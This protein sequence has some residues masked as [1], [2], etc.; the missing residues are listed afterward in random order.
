M[1]TYV[2]G[3]Q[4]KQRL[5]YKHYIYVHTKVWYVVGFP[6]KATATSIAEV[7]VRYVNSKAV[8]KEKHKYIHEVW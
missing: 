2:S 4:G 6:V 5:H 8:L 3:M 1:S 7:P